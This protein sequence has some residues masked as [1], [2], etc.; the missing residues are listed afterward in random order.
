[1]L[2]ACC[3]QTASKWMCYIVC[4]IFFCLVV[5]H[6]MHLGESGKQGQTAMHLGVITINAVEKYVITHMFRLISALSSRMV[7]E[8]FRFK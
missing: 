6:D 7:F 5:Y 8:I 1:M 3:A 2:G 4:L